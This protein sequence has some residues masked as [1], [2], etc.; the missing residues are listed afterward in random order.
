MIVPFKT[1]DLTRFATDASSHVD[2]FA[3]FL[4]AL[5]PLSRYRAD[6]LRFL[7]LNV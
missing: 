1:S 3:N 2:V 7:Y 5:R 6:G 4:G